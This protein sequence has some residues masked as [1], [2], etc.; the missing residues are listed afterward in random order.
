MEINIPKTSAVLAS[1]L[2]ADLT[3]QWRNRRSLV[4]I[5]FV[6]V[7]ILISWKDIIDKLGGAFALSACITIGLMAIGLMGYSNS[8]ARDRDKGVFPKTAGSPGC[9]VEHY[10]K[11][12]YRTIDDDI[13]GNGDCILC[14]LLCRPHQPYTC[15]LRVDFFTAMIGG[16]VYLVWGR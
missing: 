8:I 7:I 6:P 13:T 4:L 3:T 11:P 12:A 10:G 15:W 5:I 2:R 1:L 16:A 14:R 9:V